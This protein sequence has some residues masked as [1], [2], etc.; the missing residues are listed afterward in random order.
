MCRYIGYDKL[1][2]LFFIT[3]SFYKLIITEGKTQGTG[4]SSLCNKNLTISA[5][6]LG[7]TRD[8]KASTG[9]SRWFFVAQLNLIICE[10]NVLH[11]APLLSI[12]HNVELWERNCE[13]VSEKRGRE[14]GWGKKWKTFPLLPTPPQCFSNPFPQLPI[15][16][17]PRRTRLLVENGM[18]RSWVNCRFL[19]LCP[20]CSLTFLTVE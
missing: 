4:L 2:E 1:R 15:Y 6:G 10:S 5:I 8:H 14:M 18:E 16:R 17:S 19:S 12:R 7:T 13:R 11:I 3:G 20:L 9:N